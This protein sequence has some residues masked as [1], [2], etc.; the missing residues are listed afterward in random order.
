MAE[1]CQYQAQIDAQNDAITDLQDERQKVL[2][3]SEYSAAMKARMVA[4]YD[5]QIQARQDAV[6]ALE[7]ECAS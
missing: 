7:A 4:T 5:A 6:A 3:N 1:T 2:D